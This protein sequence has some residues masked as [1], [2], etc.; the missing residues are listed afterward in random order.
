MNILGLNRVNLNLNIKL[1][2]EFESQKMNFDQN[3]ILNQSRILYQNN[4]LHQ[5]DQNVNLN[6]IDFY[7]FCTKILIVDAKIPAFHR[8]MN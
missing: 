2:C 6:Q 1:N 5:N 3:M 8:F 7:R 4:D